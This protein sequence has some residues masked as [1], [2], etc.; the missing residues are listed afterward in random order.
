MENVRVQVEMGGACTVFFRDCP[1]DDN[2][3]WWA[4]QFLLYIRQ[5]LVHKCPVLSEKTLICS[6]SRCSSPLNA[7]Q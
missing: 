2:M 7:N 1:F 5:M 6:F 4:P 3:Q